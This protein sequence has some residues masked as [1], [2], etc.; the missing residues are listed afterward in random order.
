MINEAELLN[1]A[2]VNIR[3]VLDF[4]PYK[5]YSGITNREEFK[6][7]IEM[8]PAFGILGL[9]DEKYVIARIG[10]NLITSLHRKLG[11]MYQAL[12]SYILTHSFGLND[13]DLHFSVEVKIGERIQIRSTDGLIRKEYFNHHIPQ[14]WTDYQGV[15]FEVRSCYQIGDSKRIQADYDMSLVLKS[16]KILPVMLIF[17]NTSL[18]SPVTRLSKSWELYEGMDSFNLIESISGFDLHN[19]MTKNSSLLKQEIHNILNNF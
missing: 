5:S 9:N 15:G 17:C 14:T 1:L 6:K 18:R 13:Q 19:F 8:D 3:K 10:G 4:N 16:Y 11:D 7:L 2:L 12:F